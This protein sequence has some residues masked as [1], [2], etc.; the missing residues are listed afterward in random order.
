MQGPPLSMVTPAQRLW[1]LQRPDGLTMQCE[2]APHAFGWMV[3]FTV[4][5]QRIGGHRFDSFDGAKAWG[6]E[7]LANL[8]RVMPAGC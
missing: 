4:D 7:F 2:V 6:N 3:W 8:K 5:T 1:L